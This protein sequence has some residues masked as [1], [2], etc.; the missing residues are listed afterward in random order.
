MN[1]VI[2]LCLAG[3]AASIGMS[4]SA[5]SLRCS[6][7]LTSEGDSKLSVL[8]KCGP[9]ALKDSFCA[10]VYFTQS[11]QP[12]PEPIASALVPCVLTEQWLYERG[13]GNMLATVTLRSGVV[14]SI[15][16]G[17]EPQ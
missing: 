11:L 9:S 1:T 2:R 7:G 8:Y 3:W 4:A 6:G 14:R 17:R 10:P 5:E 12:V 16:Y 15:S 13:P